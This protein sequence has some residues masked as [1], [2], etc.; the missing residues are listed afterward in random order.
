MPQRW[1]LMQLKLMT[2]LTSDIWIYQFVFHWKFLVRQTQ[3]RNKL[4][5]SQ[6]QKRAHAI[7]DHLKLHIL[8]LNRTM[9]RKIPSQL[10]KM[11]TF[12]VI[13]KR[14][15]CKQLLLK[16]YWFW[17]LKSY[18]AYPACL[19]PSWSPPSL[20]PPILIKRLLYSS[21]LDSSITNKNHTIQDSLQYLMH[22][23]S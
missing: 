15:Y 5:L 17:N 11:L 18:Q 10:H 21:I 8:K 6:K 3:W 7:S 4:R 12:I 22:D 1:L 20:W 13:K 2:K 19:S 16:H 9:S 14:I 23:K